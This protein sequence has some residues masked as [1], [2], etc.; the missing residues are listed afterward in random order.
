MS[1]WFVTDY[2]KSLYTTAMTETKSLIHTLYVGIFVCILIQSML[3][4]LLSNHRII[5][6]VSILI[7]I[8]VLSRIDIAIE[9]K[10][11]IQM[12]RKEKLFYEIFYPEML[13]TVLNIPLKIRYDQR[14]AW[15]YQNSYFKNVVQLYHEDFTLEIFHFKA[16]INQNHL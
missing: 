1:K 5:I 3:L 4:I 10:K 6:A 15:P 16:H 14:H 12:V 13:E 8:I 11:H 7:S 9:K 2:L